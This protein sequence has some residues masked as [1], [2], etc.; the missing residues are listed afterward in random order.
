M[1]CMVDGRDSVAI[2]RWAGASR[3]VE[4]LKTLGSIKR[5]RAVGIGLG[6]DVVL[7]LF[8]NSR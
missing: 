4:D 2:L 6:L 7:V 1:A 8:D 5:E 3:K